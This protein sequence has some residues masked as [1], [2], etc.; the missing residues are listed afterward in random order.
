MKETGQ[1]RGSVA[2]LQSTV[3]ETPE[4]NIWLETE[5]RKNNSGLPVRRYMS[6]IICDFEFL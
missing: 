2:Y 3:K 4:Y 1:D 5:G 6:Y